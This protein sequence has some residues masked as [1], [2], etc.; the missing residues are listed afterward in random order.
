MGESR[1]AY[2]DFETEAGQQAAVAK[3][4]GNLDGRRLLIKASSDFQGRPKPSTSENSSV[5]AILKESNADA[6]SS[7]SKTAR[8]IAEKQKNPVG[9]TLFI[10]NLGFETTVCP[11]LCYS[12]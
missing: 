9:P 12:A 11:I 1:F 8:K 2:V 6:T 4:E 10:G 5:A 3:S 7:L